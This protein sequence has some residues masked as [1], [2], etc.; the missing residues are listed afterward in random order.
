MAEQIHACARP[1][2]QQFATGRDLERAAAI[3]RRRHAR[4]ANGY[5]VPACIVAGDDSLVVIA[6]PCGMQKSYFVVA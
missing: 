6:P 2:K 1:V 5:I 4:G 3:P